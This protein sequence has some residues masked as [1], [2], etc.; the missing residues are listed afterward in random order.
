MGVPRPLA[1]TQRGGLGGGWR[2][3]C[4]HP[5]VGIDVVRDQQ[6]CARLKKGPPSP[7]RGASQSDRKST[8]RAAG[9]KRERWAVDWG[10]WG[11]Q[12]ASRCKHREGLGSCQWSGVGLGL[13]VVAFFTCLFAGSGKQLMCEQAEARGLDA[14]RLCPGHSAPT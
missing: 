6:A 2:P 3:F 14:R 8:L 7:A 11:C 9:G 10:G 5:E 4:T 1:H 12:K 13:D